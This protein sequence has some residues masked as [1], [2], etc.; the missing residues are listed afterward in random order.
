GNNMSGMIKHNCYKVI[1]EYRKSIIMYNTELELTYPIGV[2]VTAVVGGIL[3]FDRLN[4]A[5]EFMDSINHTAA[6]IVRAI[7]TERMTLP[8]V[9][10]MPW[11]VLLE[12]NQ[13]NSS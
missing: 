2:K 4:A 11:G 1:T 3:T 10:I 8:S 5:K 7:G 6:I 12:F 9:R 13:R